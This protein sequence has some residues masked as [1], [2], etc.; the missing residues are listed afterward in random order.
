VRHL[1]AR[2]GP[3]A[4]LYIFISNNSTNPQMPL[5]HTNDG[6]SSPQHL[7]A[8]A[9]RYR[10]LASISTQGGQSADRQLVALAIRLE[11]LADEIEGKVGDVRFSE[12]S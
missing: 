9:S 7:R 6:A 10:R 2:C 4:G 12:A 8:Q 1:T 5:A 3:L 11:H